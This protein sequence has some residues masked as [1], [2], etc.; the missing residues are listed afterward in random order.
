MEQQYYLITDT[1]AGYGTSVLYFQ[2]ADG[3]GGNSRYQDVKWC[4]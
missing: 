4:L 2:S 1:G 3:S